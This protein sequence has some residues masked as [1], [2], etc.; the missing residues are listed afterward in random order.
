MSLL[1]P[2]YCP[3]LYVCPGDCVF[4]REFSVSYLSIRTILCAILSEGAHLLPLSIHLNIVCV[5][6]FGSTS[7]ASIYSFK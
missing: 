4:V 3:P 7:S 2:L 1:L 6:D 5:L